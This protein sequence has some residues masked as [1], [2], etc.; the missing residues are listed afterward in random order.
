MI[1]QI[2]ELYEKRLLIPDQK[3][4]HQFILC[5]VGLVGAGKTTVVKP[6][7]E[8]LSLLRISGDEIRRLLRE[9]GHGYEQV[10]EIATVLVKKYLDL[11]YS[12]CSDNDCVTQ[13]TQD[14]MSDHVKNYGLK[15]VWIHINPPEEFILHK[16]N[17]HQGGWFGNEVLIK[18]YYERKHLHANLIFPF[19]YTFDTSK[20]NLDQQIDE[21][22]GIIKQ[23][24]NN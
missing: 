9:N 22:A 20:R 24:T 19:V 14:I 18:N 8:K 6:S 23:F 17:S 11:G 21:A 10:Q 3:P 16:L 4:K 5:P 15:L 13:K 12:I 1:G 7:S 2:T